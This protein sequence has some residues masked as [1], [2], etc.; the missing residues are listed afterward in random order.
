MQD[1]GTERA[2]YQQDLARFWQ[3]LHDPRINR[4]SIFC[5]GAVTAGD[6]SWAATPLL[7]KKP[8]ENRKICGKKDTAS[9]P[10]CGA[11]I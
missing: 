4:R 11:S 5:G 1:S 2:I 3:A 9:V 10:R 7:A 6:G 8:A